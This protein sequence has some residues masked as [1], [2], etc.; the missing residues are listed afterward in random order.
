[1]TAPL[2]S[3]TAPTPDLLYIGKGVLYL[4]DHANGFSWHVGNATRVEINTTDEV[5]DK[6]SSMEASA[7]IYARRLQRRT[8]TIGITLDEYDKNNIAAALMGEH[9]DVTQTVTPVVDQVV[10]TAAV[11]GQYRVPGFNLEAIAITLDADGTPMVV[12]VDFEW[13]DKNIGLFRLL[14][15]SSVWDPGD[16]LTASYTAAAFASTKIRGGVTP[17]KQYGVLFVGDPSA[18]PPMLVEVFNCTLAPTAPFQLISED[19]APIELEGA[20][21]S[22][23]AGLYGGT[24]DSPLYNVIGLPAPE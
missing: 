3:L 19:Y 7:P 8:V 4:T 16:E 5:L 23:A 2:T 6:Y 9:E 24:E 17:T 15:P 18:G 21:Q 14:E 22:D 10:G 1:M 11:N 20:V 13:V 12:D